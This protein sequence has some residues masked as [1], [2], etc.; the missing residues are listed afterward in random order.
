MTA[1]ALT[2]ILNEIIS[3]FQSKNII[4]RSCPD[5]SI[6]MAIKNSSDK[7][8]EAYIFRWPIEAILSKCISKYGKP[9]ET[10]FNRCKLIL[11]DIEYFRYYVLQLEQNDIRFLETVSSCNSLEELLIKSDLYA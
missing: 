9:L 7:L 8:N 10:I 1:N 6:E 2:N 3:R 5:S 11:N 4:F